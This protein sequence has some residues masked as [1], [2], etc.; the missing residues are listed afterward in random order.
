[1]PA[2]LLTALGYSTHMVGKWCA[3]SPT[4]TPPDG[5]GRQALAEGLA[6]CGRHLGFESF[7]YT[8]LGRGFD[9]YYG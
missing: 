5:R 2:A 9:S 7:E 6:C 8:P 3:H 1:M 4:P